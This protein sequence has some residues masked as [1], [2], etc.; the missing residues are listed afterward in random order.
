MSR[1][2]NNDYLNFA[3]LAGFNK[4]NDLISVSGLARADFFT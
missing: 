4:I 2:G 3:A 1:G